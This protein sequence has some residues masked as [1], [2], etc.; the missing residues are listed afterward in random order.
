MALQVIT[1]M[2][3]TEKVTEF[4][5]LIMCVVPPRADLPNGTVLLHDP[6]SLPGFKIKVTEDAPTI[7]VKSVFLP[8]EKMPATPAPQAGVGQ[9]EQAAPVLD[10]NKP[11]LKLFQGRDKHQKK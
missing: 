5:T 2:I 3:D 8:E 9:V 11:K 4:G 10:N 1:V 6:L 7:S